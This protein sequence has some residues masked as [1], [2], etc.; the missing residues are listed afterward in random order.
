MEN[1]NSDAFTFLIQKKWAFLN[2]NNRTEYYKHINY[3]FMKN[4]HGQKF[5]LSFNFENW[6]KYI[7]EW[8]NIEERPFF[9]IPVNRDLLKLR[10]INKAQNNKIQVHNFALCGKDLKKE[11]IF[12]KVYNVSPEEKGL[13][14]WGNFKNCDYSTDFDYIPHKS[15]FQLD[16]NS[17]KVKDTFLDS[18]LEIFLKITLIGF[19]HTNIAFKHP[20]IMLLQ[21][22][23]SDYNMIS[24][25]DLYLFDKTTFSG[26]I[27][28]FFLLALIIIQG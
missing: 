28:A 16:F 17:S 1:L 15:I 14:L 18:S 24:N 3:D 8:P 6:D 13:I 23:L 10:L 19:I 11:P 12:F 2:V 25:N 5:S 22:N 20:F 21:G 4:R 9:S 7:L 27:S 26:Q